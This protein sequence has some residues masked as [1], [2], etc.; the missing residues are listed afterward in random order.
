MESSI[1]SREISYECYYLISKKIMP[2]PTHFFIQNND[3]T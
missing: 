3:E 1:K 2:P